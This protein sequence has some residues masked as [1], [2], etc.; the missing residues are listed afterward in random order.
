MII[1]DVIHTEFTDFRAILLNFVRGDP[2]Y[3][4]DA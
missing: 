2:S 4:V 1:N 3:Y